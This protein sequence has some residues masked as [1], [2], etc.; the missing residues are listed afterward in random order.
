MFIIM[1]GVDMGMHLQI[2]HY[3]LAVCIETFAALGYYG[4]GSRDETHISSLGSECVI[5]PHEQRPRWVDHSLHNVATSCHV[6]QE[7]NPDNSFFCVCFIFEPTI[8]RHL[9]Y[10]PPDTCNSPVANK[11][12]SLTLLG[13]PKLSSI[14]GQFLGFLISLMDMLKLIFW[15]F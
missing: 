7:K 6:P 11:Y 1:K 4:Q 3:F 14:Q 9:C 10:I 12:V 2:P 13:D 15:Q 5:D 8:K